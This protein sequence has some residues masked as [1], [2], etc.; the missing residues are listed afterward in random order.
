M[1]PLFEHSGVIVLVMKT[2]VKG[3]IVFGVGID[4]ETRCA[5]Y[6]GESDVIAIKFYCCRV[7]YPCHACH[8]AEASHAPRVW[9]KSMW[10]SER[11]ILCGVCG[12]QQTVNEY[13]NHESFCPDCKVPFNPGC[14]LHHH[15]V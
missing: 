12:R 3:E 14:R 11:A 6:R 8:A 7:W 13:M 4:P 2:Q 15:L 1:D 9:P 10:E 5:H